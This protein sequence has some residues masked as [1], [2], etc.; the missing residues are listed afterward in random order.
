MAITH[1]TS[2]FSDW[3]WSE[4]L[5]CAKWKDWHTRKWTELEWWNWKNISGNDEKTKLLFFLPWSEGGNITYTV[6]ASRIIE[7]EEEMPSTFCLSVIS[8]ILLRNG[9]NGRIKKMKLFLVFKTRLTVYAL[10]VTLLCLTTQHPSSCLCF[11][12]FRRRF[13]TSPLPCM[14]AYPLPSHHY[15][16]IPCLSRN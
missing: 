2:T 14:T 5:L 4:I 6:M 7:V 16:C 3:K 9:T 1:F 13:Y 10:I 8:P 12:C 11:I 15:P